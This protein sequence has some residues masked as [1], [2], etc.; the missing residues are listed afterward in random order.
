MGASAPAGW[1]GGLFRKKRYGVIYNKKEGGLFNTIVWLVYFYFSW[2][3]LHLPTERIDSLCLDIRSRGNLDCFLFCSL[4]A[5]PLLC[6]HT[7]RSSL[8]L[9]S[10][11]VVCHRRCSCIGRQSLHAWRS[12][13]D[14]LGIWCKRFYGFGLQTVLDYIRGR[15]KH[16]NCNIF[17]VVCCERHGLRVCRLGIRGDEIV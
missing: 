14:P 6:S 17:F 8:V 12:G 1:K 11:R 7:S 10:F 3:I 5:K 13:I 9:D 4:W 16:S 15:G 2:I